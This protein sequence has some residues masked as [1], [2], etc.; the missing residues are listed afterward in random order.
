[1]EPNDSAVVGVR[2]ALPELDS[3]EA[4]SVAANLRGDT[5]RINGIWAPQV[6]ICEQAGHAAGEIS[7]R[8]HRQRG[9][10]HFTRFE[11]QRLFERP[12]LG[13]QESMCA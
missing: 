4:E 9:Q 11:A 5:R 1:M 12:M 2:W 10:V 13:E 3:A 7:E 6:C 8:E